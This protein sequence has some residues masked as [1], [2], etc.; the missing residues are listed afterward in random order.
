LQLLRLVP[1]WVVRKGELWRLWTF[2]LCGGGGLSGLFSAGFSVA[3]LGAG[4]GARLERALGSLRLCLLS[5]LAS[6]VAAFLFLLSALACDALWPASGA[7]LWAAAGGGGWA[8]VLV[9]TA[10]ESPLYPGETRRLFFLPWEVPTRM[11]P[12]ALA[13]L[14][15]L[16]GFGGGSGGGAWLGVPCALGAGLLLAEDAEEEEVDGA[17]DA[18][19]L[20][21]GGDRTVAFLKFLMPSTARLQRWEGS[22]L[23]AWLIGMEG[24][25]RVT[26]ASGRR[27]YEN[28]VGDAGG[29]FGRGTTA[30]NGRGGGGNGSSGS[31]SSSGS[32]VSMGRGPGRGHVLGNGRSSARQAAA[33]PVTRSSGGVR[34]ESV[35]S[36]EVGEEDGFLDDEELGRRDLPAAA[37]AAAERRARE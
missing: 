37:A 24:Y 3:L 5:A 22:L 33:A 2:G 11:Y 27:A 20:A 1:L 9:W 23:C 6:A 7:M 21:G 15:A 10:L 25:V 19:A 18:N 13:V 12:V 8:C 26:E 4:L 17:V 34:Y 36:V 16:F 32:S 30:D 29:G 14:V 28:M 35:P 31:S